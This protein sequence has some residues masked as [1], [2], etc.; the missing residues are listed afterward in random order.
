MAT[1]IRIAIG[2][3]SR[4]T[5]H[6][7][8]TGFGAQFE[9]ICVFVCMCVILF[10]LISVG[11][12]KETISTEGG[13]QSVVSKP[14]QH[15]LGEAYSSLPLPH[16]NTSFCALI[17]MPMLVLQLCAIDPPLQCTHMSLMISPPHRM[18][19]II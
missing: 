16:A 1:N 3:H 14:M 13:V 18:R 2:R 10:V 9:V 12:L 15:N 4:A 8:V 19:D 7:N 6:G 5:Q 11:G 17:V